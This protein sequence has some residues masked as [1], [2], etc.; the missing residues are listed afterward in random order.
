MQFHA[1]TMNVVQSDK[2]IIKNRLKGVLPGKNYEKNFVQIVT[3]FKA[4][5]LNS[6]NDAC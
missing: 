3:N 5:K 4:V 1:G 2:K 6:V